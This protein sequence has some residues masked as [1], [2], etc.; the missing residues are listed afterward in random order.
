MHKNENPTADQ[1]PEITSLDARI[2]RAGGTSSRL[3]LQPHRLREIKAQPCTAG[4]Q[5]NDL[6]RENGYLRQEIVFYQ[7]SRNSMLAFHSQSLEA[8]HG[9]QKALRDL[10]EKS[11]KARRADGLPT[12]PTFQQ[13]ENTR[14]SSRFS[15]VGNS[16]DNPLVVEDNEEKTGKTGGS[17]RVTS[18]IDTVHLKSSHP[19]EPPKTHG[20]LGPTTTGPTTEPTSSLSDRPI[21]S[22]VALSYDRVKQ[23]ISGGDHRAAATVH[24]PHAIT[25]PSSLSEQHQDQGD[26]ILDEEDWEI[27]RI[28]GE[29]R[30]GKG[31]EYKLLERELGNAQ[32]LLRES[33]AK[34]QAQR[35]GK[36]GRPARADQGR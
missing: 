5:L 25:V 21:S 12:L 24:P 26:S 9:L 29:R 14:S 30:R 33:E 27:A 1:P 16:Q 11:E 23:A 31:Y 34:R 2:A 13:R 19:R 15:E 4:S 3:E 18:M 6:I 20:C 7:E 32:E 22:S 28:V 36:R 8:Y 17:A 10:S 35:G